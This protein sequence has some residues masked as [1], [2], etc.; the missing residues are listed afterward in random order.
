MR[1]RTLTRTHA[2]SPSARGAFAFW[3]MPTDTERAGAVRA[4]A[5]PLWRRTQ[6]LLP[7]FVGPRRQTAPAAAQGAKGREDA[8]RGLG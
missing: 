3:G 6:G 2:R 7:A 8:G 4:V 5:R 1:Q